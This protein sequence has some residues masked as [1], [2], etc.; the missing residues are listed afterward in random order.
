MGV[1]DYV[2]GEKSVATSCGIALHVFA[3]GSFN[4]RATNLV[5]VV[6]TIVVAVTFPSGLKVINP[7]IKFLIRQ[8]PLSHVNSQSTHSYTHLITYPDAVSIVACEFSIATDSRFW[9]RLD[10]IGLVGS[11]LAIVV[12][13][14]NPAIG[15]ASAAR[16]RKLIAFTSVRC[17]RLVWKEA[18]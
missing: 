5:R 16:A 4:R 13:V 18:R 3:L 10:A 7:V 9:R 11:G 2:L 15:D 17:R 1:V 12:V 8:L 14:A 6:P